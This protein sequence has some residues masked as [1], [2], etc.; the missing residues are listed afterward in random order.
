MHAR[1]WETL[2]SRSSC[3]LSMA[4]MRWDA[5]L[6]RP[7]APVPKSITI[8][9]I[10]SGRSAIPTKNTSPFPEIRYMTNLR[11][12]CHWCATGDN[13]VATQK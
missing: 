6:D 11:L 7:Y 5:L 4:K 10:Q 1:T 8:E 13:S 9:L 12:L 2:L 3:L